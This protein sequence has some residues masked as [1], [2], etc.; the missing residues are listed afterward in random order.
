MT[1]ILLA[2]DEKYFKGEKL[3]Y[4]CSKDGCDKCITFKQD[5]KELIKQAKLEL[6]GEIL[7]HRIG[8]YGEENKNYGVVKFSDILAIKSEIEKEVSND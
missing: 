4:E 7:K 3:C 1:K 6:I 2:V 8:W 5:A